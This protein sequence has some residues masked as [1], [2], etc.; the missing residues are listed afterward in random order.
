MRG[1]RSQGSSV[2]PVYNPVYS[3]LRSDCESSGYAILLDIYVLWGSPCVALDIDLV[4]Q[5][6]SGR[7]S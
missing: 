4:L 6:R 7:E 5:S 1:P 2:F 3:S